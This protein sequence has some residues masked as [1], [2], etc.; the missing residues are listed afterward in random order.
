MAAEKVW[1]LCTTGM[2]P[3]ELWGEWSIEGD[4]IKIVAED[5]AK[6]QAYIGQEQRKAVRVM[7]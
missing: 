3:K 5:R 7:L 6:L 1:T 2:R 4:Q